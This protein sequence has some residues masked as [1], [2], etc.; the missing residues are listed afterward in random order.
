M[1]TRYAIENRAFKPE[2]THLYLF[3]M[4]PDERKPIC[5][6]CN[7]TLLIVKEYNFR[8]HFETRH[9][10]FNNLYPIK[11]SS[12]QSKIDS[13]TNS[14]F[15]RQAMMTKSTL[16]Q[17]KATAASYRVEWILG[18]K[19][20]P[21][22]DSEIVKECMMAVIEEMVTE[23][24]VKSSLVDDVKQIPLS[25][26]TAMRRI[27]VL[28]QEVKNLVIA[29]LHKVEYFS[30]AVDESTD[31]TDIAQLSLFVRYFDDGI[32]REELFGFTPIGDIYNWRTYF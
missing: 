27:H 13:A 7:E 3:I 28:G 18:S 17:E 20:K 31:R 10:S 8:R 5:L 11:S 23:E 9:P 26:T 30:L 4:T 22:M 19:K 1:A 24:K 2:W 6:I 15:K 25:D 14:L 16:K 29:G 32:F 21:F 12:R